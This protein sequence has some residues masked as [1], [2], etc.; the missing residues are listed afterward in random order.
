[1]EYCLSKG[2]LIRLEGGKGGLTLCCTAGTVWLTKGDGI[3]YLV[4]AGSRAQLARGEHALV[5]A[6]TPSGLRLGNA[7][8]AGDLAMPVIGLAAC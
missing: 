2:E 6:L 8:A 1:M 5:E 7:E 4:P 3:D